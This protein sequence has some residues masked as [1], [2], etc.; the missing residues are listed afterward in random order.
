MAQP[1]RRAPQRPAAPAA[2]PAGRPTPNNRAAAPNSRADKVSA[3]ELGRQRLQ[4]ELNKQRLRKEEREALGNIPN[5]FFLKR[6]SQTTVIV[7]DDEPTFFRYEHNYAGEGAKYKNLFVECLQETDICPVC[8]ALPDSRPYYGMFLT[9]IDLTPYES[10]G[11]IVPFSRK[12]F[13]IKSNQ[14]EKFQRKVDAHIERYGTL[15][16]AVIDVFRSNSDTSPASGDDFEF[17]ASDDIDTQEAAEHYTRSWKDRA[18]KEYSETLVDVVDYDD[19]FP[20]PTV[21]E[22]EIAFGV[23]PPAGSDRANARA[24]S[25]RLPDK[26]QA[27]A[28]RVG[29]ATGRMGASAPQP[30]GR[31][32]AS[33]PAPAPT[34]RMGSAPRSRPEG[35]DN[36]P[37]ESK[38]PARPNARPQA[39]APAKP[40]LARARP[41][42]G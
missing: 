23:E 3:Y 4:A 5:R 21:E 16:G 20:T 25:A 27:P 9:I 38:A 1:P 8:K 14:Q 7:C 29:T 36:A 37:W 34:G 11:E 2:R 6:G 10:N 17:V 32:G 24:G 35:A 40:R 41:T 13:V 26:S 22:L 28:G 12:L 19:L 42:R 18:G 39:Q 30:T 15:R 31:M 33:K